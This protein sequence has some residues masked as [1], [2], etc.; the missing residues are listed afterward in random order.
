MFIPYYLLV[1]PRIK[2]ASINDSDGNEIEVYVW[3]PFGTFCHVVSKNLGIDF[4]VNR[5]TISIMR[6]LKGFYGIKL[7]TDEEL[8]KSFLD[9]VVPGKNKN[10]LIFN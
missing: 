1:P 10:T 3:G 2:L 8:S 7:S 9:I 6:I 5:D 4:M